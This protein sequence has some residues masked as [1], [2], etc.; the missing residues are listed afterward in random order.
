MSTV[1][2]H[3]RAASTKEVVHAHV[4]EGIGLLVIDNPPVNASS[5]AVR[6][7]L[8]K[9]IER[10]GADMGVSAVVLIGANTNFVSGSDLKEFD[11]EVI[12]RPELPD[13]IDAIRACPKPV[14]AALSGATL[15]GGLELALGCDYR[16]AHA[17]TMVGLPETTLGMV[18]G[19]GGT[20]RTL[21]LL[22]PVRTLNLVASGARYPVAAGEV[23][24]LVDVVT[25][26]DL[27][28]AAV[29]FA[30]SVSIKRDLLQEPV[31]ASDPGSFET[32]ATRAISASRG[33]PQIIVAV[34][35]ILAGLALPPEA[36]LA[37]ERAEFTRL[38]NG[39]QAAALR[40]VFFARR[41]V[42]KANR[43]SGGAAV[44][45][46]A[47]VGAGTMGRGIARAFADNGIDV[48][49]H[50]ARAESLANAKED[51]QDAYR[52]QEGSGQFTPEEAEARIGRVT[53][54]PRL[55]DLAGADL[56]IEAVFEDV[57][58]KKEVLRNVEAVAAG[59]TL[60]TNTS[61]LDI[62]V[63]ADA[64]AAPEKLL[65]LHFFSPAHRTP[66]LEVVHGRRTGAQA[67]DVAFTAAG[68]LRKV[69]IRSAVGE[70]F[71]GNRIF[72]AYRRQCELLLEEGA[73]PDQ[74]DA[75]MR[76]FGFAM[77][78]FAVA[79]MSGLDIAW[80]MRQRTAA[81][82]DPRERYP[83]VADQLCERGWFGQKSGRGWY[84]YGK[85]GRTP[86]PDPEVHQL[87][88]DSA[89]RKGIERRAFTHQEISHRAL[90]AMANEAALVL[91]EG[92]ADRASDIDLMLV[93]GYG[94]PDFRGGP[95]MWACQQNE[96][97]LLQALDHLERVTGF[98]FTRGDLSLLKP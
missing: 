44:Q 50:D 53:F 34:G 17:G 46:V 83:D 58:V 56:Y 10:L 29:D 24:G 90:L 61:Y 81:T 38:R 5:S 77:G 68:L 33:R 49:V 37:H 19:A 48:V 43:P 79:D 16:V 88:L 63:L 26:T 51:L 11:S 66:V 75:A 64:V 9:G 65:G 27:A 91:A 18:P 36:A 3:E 13:V 74:V 73:L 69:A 54:A 30:R 62:D 57:E 71:I 86:L 60:A 82:R 94:F 4:A 95:T 55:E 84:R 97:G 15:G 47:V 78:P 14:I 59:A 32:A 12:P 92:I 41:T 67:L 20:Q 96:A 70:G 23:A 6:A 93:L 72:N 31:P 42:S 76:Q 80:R 35:A 52:R 8:L 7:G 39:D 25:D 98:G 22:G 21:R 40:H 45:R 2:E 28:S 87:I 85:D 89:A 1:A